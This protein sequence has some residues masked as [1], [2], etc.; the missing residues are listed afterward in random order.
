MPLSQ[1]VSSSLFCRQ[2][3]DTLLGLLGSSWDRTRSLSY[4]ILARFP[5]PLAG[6][7]G[8]GGAAALSLEGLRLTGSGRQRESDRG[9][10]ILRLVFVS[11]ARGLGLDV[12]LTVSRVGGGGGASRPG[13]VGRPCEGQPQ[14][15]GVGSEGGEA[16]A[17]ARFLA[18][19]CTVLSHRLGF[20]RHS[21]D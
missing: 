13:V 18:E 10:L 9:A 4:G 7:E 17:T 3:V 5:R 8:C 2:W 19:L 21:V 20:V 12:P 1:V 11:H 6:Y 15:G 16:D 14:G